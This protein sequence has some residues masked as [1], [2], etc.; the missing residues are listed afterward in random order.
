MQNIGILKAD[1]RFYQAQVNIE[2][3]EPVNGVFMYES[4]I[5][6]RQF[7]INPPKGFEDVSDGSWF[8]TY[9]IDN[10]NVW[11]MVKDG[12]FKGFSV[13]GLFKYKKV[14]KYTNDDVLLSKIINILQQIEH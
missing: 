8:G 10:D 12:T 13:E 2:H 11:V 4:Y 7:G 1:G 3:D 5:I 6:D 9:K 14:D